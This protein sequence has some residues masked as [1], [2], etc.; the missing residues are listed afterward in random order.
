MN[1][2]FEE[3]AKNMLFTNLSDPGRWLGMQ[4]LVRD[5]LKMVWFCKTLPNWKA[6]FHVPKIQGSLYEVTFD[7]EKGMIYIDT[8]VKARNE[9]FV[10]RAYEEE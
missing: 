6:I 2:P 5:D 8:Y 9:S 3:A 4:D 10:Y 1:I 7:G